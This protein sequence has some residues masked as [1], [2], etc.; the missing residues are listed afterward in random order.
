MIRGLPLK[1]A[2]A[3]CV[4]A[5]IELHR[6]DPALHNAVSAAGVGDG[7]RRLLQQLAASWLEARRDEGRPANLALAAEIALDTAESLVHGVALRA[8]DRLANPALPKR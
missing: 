2:V 5:L 8:P 7:E 6:E 4:L 3:H 1:E